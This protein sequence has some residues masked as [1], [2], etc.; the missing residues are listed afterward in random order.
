MRFDKSAQPQ[1]MRLCKIF[2]KLRCAQ[3]ATNQQHCIS[4]DVFGFIYLVFIHREVLAQ[5]GQL[6]C[7]PHALQISVAA[8]EKLRLGEAGDG[9]GAA[10]LVGCCLLQ[11]FLLKVRSD[12]ALRGGGFLQLGD[13]AQAGSRKRCL[14]VLA[15]RSA[16]R[17]VAHSV[18]ALFNF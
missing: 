10:L 11:I 15:L 16:L 13:N 9:A 12:K 14:E 17:L 5:D 8:E 7:L 3:Q 6:D 18:E 1:L 4:A 2:A